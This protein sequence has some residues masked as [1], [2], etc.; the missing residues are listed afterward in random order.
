MIPNSSAYIHATHLAYRTHASISPRRTTHRTTP[1]QP[2]IERWD[3]D[4]A[5]PCGPPS[6][7]RYGMYRRPTERIAHGRGTPSQRDGSPWSHGDSAVE[8]TRQDEPLLYV[9][10]EQL[11][12]GAASAGWKRESHT[13]VQRRSTLSTQTERQTAFPKGN[14]SN[15]NGKAQATLASISPITPPV[16][17]GMQTG[18]IFA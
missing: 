1:A 11:Q 5:H 15:S 6:S 9:G 18:E 7:E 12:P 14:R 17:T 16:N 2:T 8:K 4:S 13:A 3:R 10:R